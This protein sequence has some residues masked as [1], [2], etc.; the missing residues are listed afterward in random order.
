MDLSGIPIIDNHVH[1]GMVDQIRNAVNFCVTQ[2]PIDER[3]RKN[4]V[5]YRMFIA[6]LR[7]YFDMPGA[8]DEE[9]MTERDRRYAV[10]PRA[11]IQKIMA[12]SNIRGLVC[13]IDSPVSA[14]WTGKYR[15]DEDLAAFVN[16]YEPEIG[17]AKIIRIEVAYN[18]RLKEK[19][20]FKEFCDTFF[21]DMEEGIKKYNV[22]G[23]KTIIAYFTGLEVTAPTEEEAKRAY[24]AFLADP[25]DFGSEK[26]FRDYML[27]L[28]MALCADKGLP[29]QVHTGFGDAPWA[30][31]KRVSP[32]LLSD[33]LYEETSMKVKTIL[34]HA[35]YPFSR[36]AA[37]LAQQVPQV[38][39]DFSEMLIFAG[40]GAGAVVPMLMEAAPLTKIM[41]GTDC[42]DSDHF[43]FGAAYTRE[44]LGDVLGSWVRKGIFTEAEAYEEAENILYKNVLSVYP[45]V[46]KQIRIS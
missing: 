7:R 18:K 14:Y 34:L 16:A 28:G 30:H 40:Q 17:V 25:S 13:D 26:I 5:S 29:L 41:Y 31:L 11:Y 10:D 33:F 9:V 27:H 44:I 21:R 35:A 15:T 6:A 8:S 42:G 38:Y 2:Y 32:A 24:E 1:P 43:H 39:V 23:I 3:D 19:L 37:I 20:D 22:V 45:G 4:L 12:D 46:E 36:E